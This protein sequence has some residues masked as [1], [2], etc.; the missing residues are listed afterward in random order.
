MAETIP[1]LRRK[2]GVW[3]TFIATGDHAAT[4]VERRPEGQ[5]RVSVGTRKIHLRVFI[6]RQHRRRR[7]LGPLRRQ[8]P[9]TGFGMWSRSNAKSSAAPEV[10]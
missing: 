1:R 2:N 8:C 3:D 10:R 4:A 7:T 6:S 9:R 5:T